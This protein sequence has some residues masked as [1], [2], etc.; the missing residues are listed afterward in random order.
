MRL[1]RGFN[2]INGPG[3]FSDAE[4]YLDCVR[5]LGNAGDRAAGYTG[6]CRTEPMVL[7]APGNDPLCLHDRAAM[8]R[9]QKRTRWHLLPPA[10]VAL[11][12]WQ[13]SESLFK[14]VASNDRLV[15]AIRSIL[16]DDLSL[17]EVAHWRQD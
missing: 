15:D 17:C 8:P 6:K 16:A 13:A 11:V 5:N 3:G 9:V 7:E 14:T 4:A 2:S 10:G 12:A 1:E